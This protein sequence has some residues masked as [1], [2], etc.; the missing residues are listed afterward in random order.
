[1]QGHIRNSWLRLW[2]TGGREAIGAYF[3]KAIDRRAGTWEVDIK[4]LRRTK[5]ESTSSRNGAL[6]ALN[7]R[8][9]VVNYFQVQ[10]DRYYNYLHNFVNILYIYIYIYT[11]QFVWCNKLVKYSKSWNA[12]QKLLLYF[13]LSFCAESHLND[14]SPWLCLLQEAATVAY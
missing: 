1:M 9:V 8:L 13:F 5:V 11:I 14:S 3:W 6:F 10:F 2:V 7:V 12:W 4:H